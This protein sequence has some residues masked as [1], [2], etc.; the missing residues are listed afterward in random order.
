MNLKTESSVS[1]E[2][3]QVHR[4]T[5]VQYIIQSKPGA[6]CQRKEERVCKVKVKELREKKEMQKERN[7]AFYTTLYF[8]ILSQGFFIFCHLI[9]RITNKTHTHALLLATDS[10]LWHMHI[11]DTFSLCIIMVSLDVEAFDL[12]CNV[13]FP[14]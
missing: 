5:D 1:D 9:P 4:S 13:T 14:H 7:Q 2:T 10:Q 6:F 12:P 3:R 8:F 11:H